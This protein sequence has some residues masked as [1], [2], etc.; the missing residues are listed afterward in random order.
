MK[1]R[2]I[3][4]LSIFTVVTMLSSSSFADEEETRQKHKD[5]EQPAAATETSS[6]PEKLNTQ[7]SIGALEG[8]DNNAFLN[9]SKK[10]D[11]FDQAFGDIVIRYMLTDNLN[12]KAIYDFMSITYHEQTSLSMLD[13]DIAGG[14]EYYIGE[15]IKVEAGYDIDFIHYIN[16]EESDLQTDG[17]FGGIRLYFDKGSYIGS[18]YRYKLYDYDE[19]NIRL[20]GNRPSDTVR[21]DHRHQ[22]IGEAQISREKLSIKAKNTFNIND[23]N[24]E[25]M[26]Y[27]DYWSNK[28]M[29]YITYNVDDKVFIMLNGGYQRKEYESRE[30]T[31]STAE[32]EDDLMILGGG[33]YY[34]VSQKF[35]VNANYTYRQNYSNDPFQEY[36]GSV[37][38]V[39]INCLF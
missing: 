13:N 34:Q 15:N 14:F 21:E 33:I 1:F 35:Y 36:S 30:I 17:P 18:K 32:Q 3:L 25:H 38:T 5:Y 16:N 20:S 22:I 29:G 6:L 31:T 19:R 11:I 10:G 4:S 8:Y 24:D 26:D 9:S 23:S 28:I 27:Y 12:I 2:A 37:G 7:F 39:G